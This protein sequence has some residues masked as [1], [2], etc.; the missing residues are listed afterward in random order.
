MMR[1]MQNKHTSNVKVVTASLAPKMETK[2][3]FRHPFTMLLAGPTSCGKSTWMKQALE[4]NLIQPAPD[5]II[6]L[7]EH[8]QPLYD[9]MKKSIPH[10][11]FCRGIP[12]NLEHANFLNTTMNNFIVID[13]L[14]IKAS[15]DDRVCDLFTKG[16]HHRNLSVAC[17]MQNL[18]YQGKGNRT[19]SLNSHYLVLFK[20]PRDMQQIMVLARQMYPNRPNQLIQEYEE[21]VA[22]PYNPLVI[23][24]K[25]DTPE[26]E[27]LRKNMSAPTAEPPLVHKS[28]MPCTPQSNK[29]DFHLS[30]SICGS[31]TK[32][33]CSSI[34][35]NMPSCEECGTFFD[36]YEY[37]KHHLPCLTNKR[38]CPETEV[39]ERPLKKIK[40]GS[41]EWAVWAQFLKLAEKPFKAKQ[42]QKQSEYEINGYTERGA[43]SQAF[44]DFVPAMRKTLRHMLMQEWLRWNRLQQDQYIQKMLKTAQELKGKDDSWEEALS[45]SLRRHKILFEYI[46]PLKDISSEDKPENLSDDDDEEV[47]GDDDENDDNEK[48]HSRAQEQNHAQKLSP[49][50][51]YEQ[52]RM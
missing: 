34:P 32:D 20:N 36:D 5:R 22:T 2:L 1:H 16:S 4:N 42:R 31:D 26:S 37:L 8:W 28:V 48:D 14:M 9:Q 30:E 21:A 50:V 24:L 33:S 18:Y 7:Y 29:P 39:N 45:E 23:D 52:I 51:C 38:F 27:R 47:H 41:D 10:I 44:N 43:Q 40:T 17:L 6:W 15:H 25:P 35:Y 3:S 11:E 13:D 46:I 12:N 49:W 19:M